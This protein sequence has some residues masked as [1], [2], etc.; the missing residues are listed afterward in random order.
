MKTIERLN[1][2]CQAHDA[3]GL[4]AQAQ[5]QL[6]VIRERQLKWADDASTDLHRQVLSAEALGD[7][8]MDRV[9]ELAELAGVGK[10]GDARQQL[11]RIGSML[12]AQ[13]QAIQD[14]GAELERTRNPEPPPRIPFP[15]G[16]VP[17]D[18]RELAAMVVNAWRG[19]RIEGDLSV[20]QL[21]AF[22]ACVVMRG[23]DEHARKYGNLIE[24]A[25]M[26]ERGEQGDVYT[27]DAEM[28]I[29]TE[30]DRHVDPGAPPKGWRPA[31]ERTF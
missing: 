13:A 3:A 2:D 18:A 20:D 15:A 8:L 19:Y 17:Y 16:E 10:H 6:L 1:L 26:G 11:E 23:Y 29:A 31:G 22:L 24:L 30:A 7:M 25:I 12:S 28:A 27:S 4:L 5:Y 14:L 9:C 21:Q